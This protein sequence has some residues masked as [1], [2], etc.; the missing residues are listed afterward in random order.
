M[1]GIWHETPMKGSFDCP[2]KGHGSHIE[3]HCSIQ[4]RMKTKKVLGQL[5][6][7]K[8]RRAGFVSRI[9]SFCLASGYHDFS[10]CS[11]HLCPCA[12]REEVRQATCPEPRVSHT[13]LCSFEV[14]LLWATSF[15]SENKYQY[16]NISLS[17]SL[18]FKLDH[19]AVPGLLWSWKWL[20]WLVLMSAGYKLESPE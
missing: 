3:N 18:F 5:I 20:S 2:Q 10:F 12:R 9:Q 7:A 6:C 1:Q 11:C 17:L 4:K 16:I 15:L 8:L 14:V 19:V 13:C